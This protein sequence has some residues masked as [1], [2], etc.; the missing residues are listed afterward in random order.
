MITDKE[1]ETALA[2]LERSRTK[3]LKAV[4]GVTEQPDGSLGRSAGRFWNMWSIWP[5]PMTGWSSW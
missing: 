3:L 1:R 4:E 2:L 5:S